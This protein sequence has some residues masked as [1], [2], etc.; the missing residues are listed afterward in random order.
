MPND[1][2]P[3][4]KPSRQYW[5]VP[6]EFVWPYWT[7]NHRQSLCIYAAMSPDFGLYEWADLTADQQRKIHTAFLR[8]FGVLT[9]KGHTHY[10]A[11][12]AG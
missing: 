10:K 5:L 6:F 1:K 2:A 7:A 9:D 3:P 8:Q 12:G 4:L 11:D